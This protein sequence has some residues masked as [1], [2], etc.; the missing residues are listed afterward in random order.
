M[1]PLPFQGGASEKL[2]SENYLGIRRSRN[3]IMLTSVCVVRVRVKSL[4]VSYDAALHSRK[5]STA[6][7]VRSRVKI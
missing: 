7:C 4:L 2:G 5:T 6:I 3:A 1:A